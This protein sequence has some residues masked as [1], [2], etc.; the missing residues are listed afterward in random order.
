MIVNSSV[1]CIHVLSIQINKGTFPGI[2]DCANA[3]RRCESTYVVP[4]L[5]LTEIDPYLS[6]C[7]HRQSHIATLPEDIILSDV[8]PTSRTRPLQ[9][10]ATMSTP[11]SL[12]RRPSKPL[13][14]IRQP[15]PSSRN[16]SNRPVCSPPIFDYTSLIDESYEKKPE[17]ALKYTAWNASRA[18]TILV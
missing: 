1:S 16:M 7:R 3:L 6:R 11:P 17:A 13:N 4:Q 8:P 18:T 2:C 15:L 10:I 9:T 14:N 12:S 5:P